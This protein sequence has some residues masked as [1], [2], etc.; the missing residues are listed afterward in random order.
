VGY[1]IRRVLANVPT[2]PSTT[3]ARHDA[4][5]F[6]LLMVCLRQRQEISSMAETIREMGEERARLAASVEQVGAERDQLQRQVEELSRRFGLDST[7]SSKPPSSDGLKRKPRCA[8]SPERQRRRLLGRRPGKQK[9]APGHH[10]EQVAHPDNVIQ[11]LPSHCARCLGSLAGPASEARMEK[12]QVIDLPPPSRLVITEYQ[13]MVLICSD[14]G[15]ETKAEFPEWAKAPVSYGPR[16]HAMVNYLGAYQHTPL[17]RMAEQVRDIYGADVSVGSLVAMLARGGERVGPAVEE[18]RRQLQAAE[19]VHLDET[20]AH[21]G[22]ELKWVHGAATDGL[23]LLGIDDRRGAEGIKAMGVT[24]EFSGIAIH[25]AWSSYWGTALPK[26]R[27]HGLCNAHHLRELA[28]V[29]ELDGQRW[30]GRMTNLLLGMLATRNAAM[31]AGRTELESELVAGF[32]R[33]YQRVI[34]SGWRENRRRP[35]KH[36]LS[37]AANLLRRLDEHRVEVLRFLHD[38]AVSFTNNEIERDL[39]MIKLHEKISGGWR[40][41]DG[42]RGFLNVRSYLATARKQ[43]RG[44]LQVLTGVFE[45]Q[46]WLPAA[47]GP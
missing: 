20:G 1:G 7:N 43:G 19:V 45:G 27:G 47:A 22:G 15:E 41:M 35:G 6:G 23:T 42:A 10:L 4:L 18:I 16:L 39:R 2:T 24:E 46:P 31:E 26:V 34:A 17:E 36:Q 40:S 21:V 14:C 29:S 28:A 37:Q 30:S 32:E 8:R 9:G 5:T 13:A 33:R 44:M 3:D 11:L 38:F 12:R 25:D